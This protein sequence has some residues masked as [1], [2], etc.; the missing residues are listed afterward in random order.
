MFRGQPG[1]NSLRDPILKK[2]NT[3]KRAGE[4]SQVVASVRS[5]YCTK[6]SKDKEKILKVASEK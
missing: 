2:P 1:A 4:V 5:Q 3:K 6:E